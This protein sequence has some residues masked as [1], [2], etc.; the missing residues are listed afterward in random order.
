MAELANKPRKA[1]SI[2][3][4]SPT[5]A[6]LLSGTTSLGATMRSRRIHNLIAT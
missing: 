6:P 4:R 2:R 5:S 3:A 1:S